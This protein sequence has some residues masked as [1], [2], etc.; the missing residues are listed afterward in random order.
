MRRTIKAH[1]NK[2]ELT[3]YIDFIFSRDDCNCK[4]RDDKYWQTL[5][6]KESLDPKECLM[7]GD[8]S[9]QDIEMPSKFGFQTMLVSSSEDL[10][11][12]VE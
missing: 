1:L 2:Y 10:K 5:I 12:L 3:E 9:I 6:K 8:D 7:I 11:K 4:K